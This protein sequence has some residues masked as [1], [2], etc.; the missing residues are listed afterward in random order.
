MKNVM[1]AFLLF[2]SNK[3]NRIQIFSMENRNFLTNLLLNYKFK[4]KTSRNYST[5]IIVNKNNKFKMNKTLSFQM[6]E[7]DNFHVIN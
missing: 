6:G 3:V 2:A 1:L 5:G 7:T 4:R